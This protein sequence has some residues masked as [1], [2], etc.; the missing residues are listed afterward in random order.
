MLADISRLK[1]AAGE[2]RHESARGA[3]P[4]RLA[5]TFGN[6]DE[7]WQR[8]ARRV[9]RIGRGRTGPNINRIGE[10]GQTAQQIHQALAIPG[11]PPTFTIN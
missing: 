9:N 4:R 1:Q 10:I 8:L 5:Q 2:F 3:D 6:F 11:Y 7:H